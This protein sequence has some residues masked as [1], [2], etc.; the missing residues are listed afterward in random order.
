LDKLNTV[1]DTSTAFGA[2]TVGNIQLTVND[3]RQK[4]LLKEAR[5]L[6]VKEAK[7]KAQ[8]LSRSAGISLGRI[9]NVQ[10]SYPSVPRPM[11]YAADMKVGLGGGSETNIQTG[12]TDIVSQVTLYYETR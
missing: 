7:T 4:E 1:I 5:D 2:N 8:E 6:A 3:D 11:M 10:E 9:V 12:S